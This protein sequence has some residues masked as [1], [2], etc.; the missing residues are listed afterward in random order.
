MIWLITIMGLLVFGL[1]T[2]MLFFSEG[3]L[4]RFAKARS[5]NVIRLEHCGAALLI[6][7]MGMLL[8]GF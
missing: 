2:V 3:L 5:E 4:R 7:S 8:V 1:G 6:F